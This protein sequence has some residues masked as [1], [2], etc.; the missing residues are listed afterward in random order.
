D[1]HATGFWSGWFTLSLPARRSGTPI[2]LTASR[3]QL[4]TSHHC[5]GHCDSRGGRGFTTHQ[6]P[7]FGGRLPGPSSWA[8]GHP[9]YC[10]TSFLAGAAPVSLDL[11]SAERAMAKA[12]AKAKAKA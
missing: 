2:V 5:P 10:S 1:S 3:S 7:T 12:K 6:A 8:G 4:E 9:D 11:V